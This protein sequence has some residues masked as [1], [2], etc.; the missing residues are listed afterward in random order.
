M[1][2]IVV[3]W[4]W[5]QECGSARRKLLLVKLADQA[6]DE[7][8]CYPSIRTL[9]RHT[10]MSKSAVERE[11]KE[12]AAMGLLTIERRERLDGGNSSNLY[13]LRPC[14]TQAGQGVPPKRDGVSHPGGTESE[15]PS[16]NTSSEELVR[17]LWEAFEAE[18]MK[19]PDIATPRKDYAKRVR[20]CVAAGWTPET[21]RALVREHR[22][23]PTLKDT[24]L[25]IFS[26]TKWAGELDGGGSTPAD[27]VR[28]RMAERGIA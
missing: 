22:K 13:R 1:S 3:G 21:V 23:H 12:L 6:N 9:A 19:A 16:N 5:K 14:P 17:A 18:G 10:E 25:T 8:S 11:V 24:M 26:L 7:G 15:P 2:G 27:R 4:A 28:R 20:E